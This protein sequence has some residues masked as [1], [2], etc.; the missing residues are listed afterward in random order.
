M[1]ANN[2]VGTIQPIEEFATVVRQYGIGFHTD[3]V[4][5]VGK[6]PVDVESMGVDMLS[7]A[8][9]KLY[10]PQGIGALYV[11]TFAKAQRS[12]LS[13]TVR[14]NRT[15]EPVNDVP[16]TCSEG[17]GA[18]GGFVCGRPLADARLGGTHGSI[19]DVP[20]SKRE[21]LKLTSQFPPPRPDA[22][23]RPDRLARP[24]HCGSRCRSSSASSPL[25]RPLPPNL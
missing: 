18:L 11:C 1:L 22:R 4:Q 7:I 21:A 10:A 16:L 15:L 12:S 8:G 19:R 20:I 2:E 17:G 24:N 5:A 3:A 6:I 25:A 23:R 9:H 14:R 13:C